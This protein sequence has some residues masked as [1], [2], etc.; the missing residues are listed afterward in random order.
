[1]SSGLESVTSCVLWHHV[2]RFT[3]PSPSVFAYC[4]QSKTGAGKALGTRLGPLAW[5]PV[6]GMF[7]YNPPYKIKKP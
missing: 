5:I 7:I 1:M 6:K 2:V 4:T 3:R